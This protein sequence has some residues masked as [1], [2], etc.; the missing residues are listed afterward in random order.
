MEKDFVL[1]PTSSHGTHDRQIT[2]SNHWQMYM[3]K[4]TTRILSK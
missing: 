1:F 3:E 4:K 2:T